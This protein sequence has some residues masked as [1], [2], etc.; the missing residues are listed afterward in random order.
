MI[1]FK[2]HDTHPHTT[3]QTQTPKNTH[4]HT[5]TKKC[6]HKRTCTHTN[7]THLY[8]LTHDV[9]VL[10]V[11][12]VLVLSVGLSVDDQAVQLEAIRRF[13]QPSADLELQ[14]ARVAVHDVS[15]RLRVVAVVAE[16]VH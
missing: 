4:K 2:Q 1:T 10:F 14:V 16:A 12:A 6:A 8:S 3:A 11:R 9:P 13:V 7:K 15:E 5:I